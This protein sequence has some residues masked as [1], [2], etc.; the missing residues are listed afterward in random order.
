M[1]YGL[2][3]NAQ[4]LYFSGTGGTR[5]VAE[6]LRGQLKAQGLETE[7]SQ[8]REPY[9]RVNPH[10]SVLFLL[11]PVYEFNAPFPVID[12]LRTV[13]NGIAI[14]TVVLSVSGG[15]DVFP[16]KGCRHDAITIL[17]RKGYKIAYEDMFVLPPNVFVALPPGVSSALLSLIPAKNKRILESLRNGEVR[18]TKTTPIDRLISRK[19]LKSAMRYASLFRKSLTVTR[20]CVR[21]GRCVAECPVNNLKIDGDA[22]QVMDHC[23]FCLNCVYTCPKRAMVTKK[24]SFILLKDGY[25]LKAYEKALPDYESIP[26]GVFMSGIRKYIRELRQNR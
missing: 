6:D 25:S 14:P 24:Y 22:V 9:P 19:G 10:A 21:C 5:R 8:I 11:F 7:I 15:G 16:N 2:G 23:A 4:I 20:E 13:P 18:R 26:K 1:E 12:W 3:K 17:E